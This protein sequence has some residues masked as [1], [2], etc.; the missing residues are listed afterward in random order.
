MAPEMIV[1]TSRFDSLT[2]N[3]ANGRRTLAQPPDSV[4]CTEM[5]RIA[6]CPVSFTVPECLK[7]VEATTGAKGAARQ[8]DPQV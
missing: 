7:L 5:S 1:V 3:K 6:A 4:P 8:A 2:S